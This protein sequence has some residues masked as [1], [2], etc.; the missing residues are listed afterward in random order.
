MRS[1]LGAKS[2]NNV[3]VSVTHPG[4]SNLIAF[5][6]FCLLHSGVGGAA[7]GEE[8]DASCCICKWPERTK[9]V[10]MRRLLLI[11]LSRTF[12]E[13]TEVTQKSLD[14]LVAFHSI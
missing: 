4:M 12:L 6:Y 9:A 8:S 13:A 10:C 14:I 1:V 2:S 7:G 11:F 3:C 5:D